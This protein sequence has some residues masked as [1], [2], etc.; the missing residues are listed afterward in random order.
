MQQITKPQYNRSLDGRG[1]GLTLAGRRRGLDVAASGSAEPT[2]VPNGMLS[3]RQESNWRPLASN[4]DRGRAPM[5][6][7]N[8]SNHQLTKIALENAVK[9]AYAN[10]SKAE[11]MGLEPTTDCS[12]TDFES[13]S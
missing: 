4:V 5:P 10:R 7:A 2:A 6:H 1:R 11:G 9:A 8:W 13:A 12:A 3:C